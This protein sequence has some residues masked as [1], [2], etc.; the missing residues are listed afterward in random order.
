MAVVNVRI[1]E[2]MDDEDWNASMGKN[3]IWPYER[4]GNRYPCYNQKL[5]IC[6]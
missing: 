6:W 4:R 5:L 3:R 1:D 2:N